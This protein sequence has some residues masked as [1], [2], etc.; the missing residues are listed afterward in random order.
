MT[1]IPR[2][3]LAALDR[4]GLDPSTKGLP[5]DAPP[6]TVGDV[7]VQ[8]WNV[9]AGDLPLPLAVIREDVVRANSAWMSAFT[10]ANDLVIAPH[11]KT[12]M[13]PQ[14]F[15]LQVADGA[16]AVTVATVQ[17]LGVCVRFGVK[18][19]LIANQPVGEQAIDAC[20]RAL[21]QE[22]FELY[23]L[24]DGL[25]GLA[26]LAEGAKRNSPPAGNPLRVLVEIGFLGGRTGARTREQA[27]EVA[28]AVTETPG[29]VLGGFECFEGLLPTP[30]AADGLIDDVAALTETALGEDLFPADQPVVL[31]A[32]GSAFF[33]RVGKR[34]SRVT[35]NRPVVK[36]LRSGCYLTHD[37]ISY[38][39][40]FERIIS[41]TSL[42]LPEGRLEAALEVWAH[43]QSRPE[44]GRTMLTMGKRDVSFD[45]GMPVPLRWFRPGAMQRPETMPEG[46][47]VSALND[48]HCH[49]ET[50]ADSPLEAGDMV[51]FGIGHPCTTFDKWQMLVL[52]DE[53]YRVTRALK[54]FF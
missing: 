10:A 11:G 1:L 34:F 50:P 13:S 8:G 16:W 27:M 49:L 33:D 6:L 48:Q 39:A 41:D 54:T 47:R 36:V 51:A 53:D 30:E 35:F 24:A 15:D 42:K 38:A 17:Q 44:G 40:A 25:P 28:R 46:H 18:R 5:F 32:G 19:V 37:S 52:V 45:A 3:D 9:L 20:F 2:L 31:S 12:T 29:L 4:Q 22:G 14:L 21:R 23:C 7:G 26:L 43:V